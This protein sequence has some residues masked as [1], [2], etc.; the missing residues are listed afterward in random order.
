MIMRQ[1]T[2]SLLEQSHY[3]EYSPTAGP[4]KRL[5]N[6]SQIVSQNS[7]PSLIGPRTDKDEAQNE[8]PEVITMPTQSSSENTMRLSN[9]PVLLSTGRS[10]ACSL[11]CRCACHRRRSLR[12]PQCL[13]HV[14]GS[15]FV[16]YEVSP[17]F[18]VPCSD[19]IC[20]VN[21]LRF[22]YTYAFPRWLLSRVVQVFITYNHAS[23]PESILRIM[24]VRE[25]GSGPFAIYQAIER[26]SFYRTSLREIA[27]MIEN[28]EASVL[29]V[30]PQGWTLLHVRKCP[31]LHYVVLWL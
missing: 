8:P 12:S 24:R 21:K 11:S 23:G 31:L 1:T 19:P 30:T 25:S 28:A 5:E 17:W 3:S 20:Q 13:R 7:V 22:S 4:Q 2:Q 10:G 18:A 14:L 16:G 15:L 27:T 6:S 9:A 26:D 29:D